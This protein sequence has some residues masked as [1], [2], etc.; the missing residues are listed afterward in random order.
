VRPNPLWA[1]AVH[2]A[3]AVHN[4]GDYAASSVCA[5]QDNALP[6]K[7]DADAV[8]NDTLRKEDSAT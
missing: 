1:C 5:V 7:R 8:Y 4:T 2:N 3:A 6:G